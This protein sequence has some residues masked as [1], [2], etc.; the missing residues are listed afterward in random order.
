MDDDYH[1]F[2]RRRMLEHAASQTA[3]GIGAAAFFCFIGLIL[4]S[5]ELSRPAR[6]AALLVLGTGYLIV[7]VSLVRRPR[8]LPS[9][10][11]TAA[12]PAPPPEPR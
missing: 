9:E 12:E 4:L 2:F 5:G 8:P 7:Y 1:R 3:A 11:S 6:G 10:P